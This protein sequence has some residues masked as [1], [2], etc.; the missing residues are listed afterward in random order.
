[1]LLLLILIWLANFY[2]LCFIF[3]FQK[4]RKSPRV[5][6]QLAVAAIPVF[7]ERTRPFPSSL[8]T[9]ITKSFGWQVLNSD[10]QADEARSVTVPITCHFLSE[11][12]PNL[13]RASLF[14]PKH[15]VFT[16]VRQLYSGFVLFCFVLFC[17]VF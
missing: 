6:L 10:S 17:F 16:P 14:L 11:I 7:S 3:C 12:P 1:M 13:V 8:Y 9:E 4:A 15:F 5:E 2:P